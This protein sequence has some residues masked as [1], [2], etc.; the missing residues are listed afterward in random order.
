M[1]NFNFSS[2][3]AKTKVN[4]RPHAKLSIADDYDEIFPIYLFLSL[5]SF[6]RDA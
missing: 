2:W 6:G 4:E 5:A 3:T 1:L